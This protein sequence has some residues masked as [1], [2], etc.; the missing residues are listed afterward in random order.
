MFL[1]AMTGCVVA[2]ALTFQYFPIPSLAAV[3]YLFFLLLGI[4]LLGMTITTAR[5]QAAI[6]LKKESNRPN[7]YLLDRIILARRFT[8]E[9]ASSELV[10][11]LQ[12]SHARRTLRMLRQRAPKVAPAGG[13][14]DASMLD[15]SLHPTGALAHKHEVGLS[16]HIIPHDDA[17][18]Y[19]DTAK[20]FLDGESVDGRL[21][22]EQWR[23]VIHGVKPSKNP[24]PDDPSEEKDEQVESSMFA[25][26]CGVDWAEG[27]AEGTAW[28]LE[29]MCFLKEQRDINNGVR[30]PYR[31]TAVNNS[32][33]STDRHLTASDEL[34]PAGSSSEGVEATEGIGE[35]YGVSTVRPALKTEE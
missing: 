30:A 19:R 13:T 12:E 22:V 15:D 16:H 2:I 35:G 11:V 27:D 34:P 9:L 5:L 33:G 14:S 10:Q 6:D 26:P 1:I 7:L 32:V 21:L 4:S 17:D 8:D 18:G 28:E 23:S 3:P 24:F 25:P 29:L 31:T 20:F